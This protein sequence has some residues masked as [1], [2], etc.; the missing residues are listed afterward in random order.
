MQVSLFFIMN[1]EGFNSSDCNLESELIRKV[2]VLYV[3]EDSPWQEIL[4]WKTEVLY[5]MNLFN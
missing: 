3:I 1:L 5:V 4:R 2:M